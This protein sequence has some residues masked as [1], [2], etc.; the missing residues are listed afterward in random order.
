MPSVSPTQCVCPTLAP[1]PAPTDI[2]HH[3]EQSCHAAISATIDNPDGTSSAYTF[4][5]GETT[6]DGTVQFGATSDS[7]E[8]SSIA[9][10]IGFTYT[11]WGATYTGSSYKYGFS[12]DMTY[13]SD[14]TICYQGTGADCT[15]GT[16]VSKIMYAYWVGNY[17]VTVATTGSDDYTYTQP[18]FTMDVTYFL[19]RSPDGVVF[20]VRGGASDGQLTAGNYLTGLKVL[21]NVETGGDAGLCQSDTTKAGN[22][23]AGFTNNN[24]DTLIE[25]NTTTV[26]N[27]YSGVLAANGWSSNGVVIPAAVAE[28]FDDGTPRSMSTDEVVCTNNGVQLTEARAACVGA[29]LGGGAN[30]MLQS[31]IHDYCA[32]A[33]QGKIMESYITEM[34]IAAG[35]DANYLVSTYTAPTVIVEQYSTEVIVNLAGITSPEQ[36]MGDTEDARD[37]KKTLEL[38]WAFA[39]EIAELVQAG[40]QS[41]Y[42]YFDGCAVYV[43]VTDASRRNALK[44]N[45]VATTPTTQTVNTGGATAENL[46]T[47]A[48][49]VQATTSSGEQ[50]GITTWPFQ[51]AISA[52]DVSSIST[53]TVDTV[54]TGGGT[55]APTSSGSDD[56]LGST[57][58]I[59]IIVGVLLGVLILVVIVV[60]VVK[61]QLSKSGKSDIA[62]APGETPKSFANV[63]L[64]QIPAPPS[65]NDNIDPGSK[66]PEEQL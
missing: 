4:I 18:S 6:R 26:A 15:G 56:S 63:G 20:R 32:F 11:A 10:A 65:E 31:C 34:K 21:G 60:V 8:F 42:V 50:P 17:T 40:E 47:S 1:T 16:Q 39:L 55:V 2:C 62:D 35:V 59:F 14:G 37:K 36:I 44:L 30:E 24:F 64:K 19:I 27:T 51:A 49:A 46:A 28:C 57:E 23:A 61:V 53:T 54:A 25:Y 29:M 33:G 48:A 13:P 22:T 3:C 45:Y 38:I 58:L 52:A 7:R 66:A 9:T 12:S 41:F 5:N 43:T